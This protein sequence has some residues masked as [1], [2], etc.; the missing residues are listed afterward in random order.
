MDPFDVDLTGPYCVKAAQ[1]PYI[2]SASC[3]A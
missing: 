2:R 3:L 1:E